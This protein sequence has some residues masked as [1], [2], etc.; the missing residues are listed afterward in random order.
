MKILLILLGI[1]VAMFMWGL[2]YGGSERRDGIDL[3]DK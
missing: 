1:I 2:V 3:D